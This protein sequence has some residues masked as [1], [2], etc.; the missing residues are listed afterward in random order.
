[1][2]HDDF[3]SIGVLTGPYTRPTPSRID[4]V[5]GVFARRLD[6]TVIIVIAAWP[7]GG[8]NGSI[9]GRVIVFGR[10]GR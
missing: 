3:T 10:G 2:V 6:G 4:S 1:M 8:R 9:W 5:V 7:F